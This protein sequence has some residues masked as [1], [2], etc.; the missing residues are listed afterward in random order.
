MTDQ[1]IALWLPK[2][3]ARFEVGPA[4]YTPPAAGEV[5]VR[6]RAIAVNPIDGMQG[7]LYRVVLPWLT[8]PA[9]VGSD[10]A[11][12][13]VEVGTGVTRLRPGDRVLGHAFG[14]EKSQNRAAEGAF[15]H[16]V[17]L[18][19]H[20]VSPIP[21][22]L[23]FEQAAVLPL[24]LSTAATGMFQQDHLGL[25]MPGA[26][27]VDRS[28]TVLVW[29]GSTSVGSNAIQLARNAGYR[30]VTTASP[31]NFDFVRSLGAA[32]AVDR[33]SPTA[34]ED[35]VER[36]GDSPLAGTLAIGFGS[37]RKAIA[38]AAR[39]TGSKRVASAQPALLARIEGWRA[40]RH[41][42]RV[43]GIWGGTLKDNE[44]GPAIYVDFLPTALATGV[45][46]AAPD[47]TVV[48]HGLDRIPDALR[49]LR[50]GVSAK[51]LVVTV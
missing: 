32:E 9:V 25:A 22:S 18:M 48:G 1:N 28:E 29:G 41:G 11:G 45:Y 2:R 4:P 14:V 21:D 37:L 40:P 12:E 10:V 16:Y 30:V 17:V 43:S 51:K 38:I 49:Q 6:A 44:V 23:S 35:I 42:V 33:R 20:M 46:Q 31:H 19:E 5:V 13:V 39:T 27:P 7:F 47:A 36:I 34:V 24:T 8:F 26:D 3:G 50:D 15:Q